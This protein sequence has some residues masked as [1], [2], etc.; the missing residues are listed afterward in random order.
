MSTITSQL[1]PSSGS[2]P[3]FA[4]VD[5]SAAQWSIASFVLGGLAWVFA[6]LFLIVTILMAEFG[7]SSMHVDRG[8]VVLIT[9]GIGLTFLLVLAQAGMGLTFAIIGL[10]GARSRRQTIA[11]P[12][13]AIIVSA[14]A[15]VLVAGEG[16]VTA[17]VVSYWN[18]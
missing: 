1:S 14:L 2:P 6:P 17:A 5:L 18:R 11:L 8:E 12:V 16:I 3:A 4:A 7:P 15:L 10:Q 13:S 9:F